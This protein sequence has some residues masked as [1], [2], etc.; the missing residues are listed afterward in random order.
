MLIDNQYIKV[1]VNSQSSEHYKNLGYNVKSGDIIEVPASHLTKGC[2]KKVEI[3][4]DVCGEIFERRYSLYLKCQHEGIYKDVCPRCKNVIARETYYN[5]TGYYNP[6]QNPEIKKKTK[7]TSMLRYGTESPNQS[8]RVK[9]KKK[10]NYFDRTGYYNPS[11]NP[12]VQKKKNETYEKHTGYKFCGSSPE[13]R[14]KAF[15]TYFKRTGYYNP[16]QNPKNYSTISQVQLEL[17][18]ILDDLYGDAIQKNFKI[19]RYC[20]DFLLTINDIK[21]DIEYD[22]AYWHHDKQDLD[23]TRDKKINSQNIK[24]LRIKSGTKL[25]TTKQITEAISNL[26]DNNLNYYEIVLS[27]WY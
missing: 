20:L 13:D 15:E 26:I 17:G 16:I 8:E 22:G 7:E 2:T 14:Q 12:E 1:T 18:K 11:Q 5:K 19:F 24:V 3:K 10:K 4:C 23:Q 25:P 9:E 21:I 27:D 6:N